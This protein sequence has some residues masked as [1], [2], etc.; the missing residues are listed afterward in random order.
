MP[1][2]CALLKFFG[3]APNSG[4]LIFSEIVTLVLSGIQDPLMFVE[5]LHLLAVQKQN[6][7]KTC[8]S[9]KKNDDLSDHHTGKYPPSNTAD[10]HFCR[11]ELTPTSVDLTC[12]NAQ[13][14]KNT[15]TRTT[16][17]PM[18][19]MYKNANKTTDIQPEN[20]LSLYPVL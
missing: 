15:H 1:L 5:V 16:T 12:M 18:H 20:S 9:Y 13:R 6:R 17:M 10:S 8:I 3:P 19:T 7:D 4:P 14:L 2:T 11:P